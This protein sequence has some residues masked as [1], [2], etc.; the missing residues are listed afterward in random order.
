MNIKNIESQFELLEKRSKYVSD[1]FNPSIRSQKQHP[2]ITDLQE[3][4]LEDTEIF[5]LDRYIIKKKPPKATSQSP[6]LNT[7]ESQSIIKQKFSKKPRRAKRKQVKLE[8][9]KES[10]NNLSYKGNFSTTKLL[11]EKNSIETLP[12]K[13]SYLNFSN[14]E[15]SISHDHQFSTVMSTDFTYDLDLKDLKSY[16]E[17]MNSDYIRKSF[18]EINKFSSKNNKY[19]FSPYKHNGQL[20]RRSISVPLDLNIKYQ[21]DPNIEI[22]ADK[23]TFHVR[24]MEISQ[25]IS[26]DFYDLKTESGFIMFDKSRKL[27]LEKEFGDVYGKTFCVTTE[28]VEGNLVFYVVFKKYSKE[29]EEDTVFLIKKFKQMREIKHFNK[30]K[31]PKI[32]EN[33]IRNKGMSV[34]FKHPITEAL[35][36]Y[37]DQGK[38]Y[39]PQSYLAKLSIFEEHDYIRRRFSKS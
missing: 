28:N 33:E 4:Y 29:V 27:D 17:D 26:K 2:Y 20:T 22:K 7:K 1:Y 23:G 14:W 15:G 3:D 37:R 30:V 11:P 19:S 38:L 9:M 5:G 31:L 10:V 34:D 32:R 25:M 35:V 39:K 18:I 13:P 12:I 16:P 8:S 24:V 36:K 6:I 21:K